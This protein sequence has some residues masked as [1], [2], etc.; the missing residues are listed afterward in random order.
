MTLLANHLD[1]PEWTK[2]RS[3][4]F[5][6]IILNMQIKYYFIQIIYLWTNISLNTILLFDFFQIL[7]IIIV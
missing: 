5:E 4:I 2:C 6:I 3:Q 1:S 7:L